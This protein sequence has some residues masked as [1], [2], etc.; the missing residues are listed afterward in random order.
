MRTLFIAASLIPA[1]FPAARADIIYQTAGPF[2]SPFGLIGFDVGGPSRQRVAVRFEPDGDYRLDRISVWFMSNDFGSVSMAPVDITVE[3]DDPAGGASVPS[4]EVLEKLGFRVSALGWD[5]VLEV[6]DS[7]ERPV[8]RAGEKYWIAAA[9]D[10]L[11]ENPVWNLAHPGTGFVSVSDLAGAWQPGGSGAVVAIIVEGAPDV[12]CLADLDGDGSLTF[13][14]FLAFQ[15]LFAAGDL[16][17]D[18][19]G[20]GVLDLFDF[21]AFQN[22]FAVG[23]P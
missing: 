8:L 17:A 3:T 13:F 16:R 22:E 6:M 18:F 9:S 11:I 21:L 5:P 14:D 20:D 10:V 2:G 4:G 1:A 23:C 7:A 19:T 12:G 15:N